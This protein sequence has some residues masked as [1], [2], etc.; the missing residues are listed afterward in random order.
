[1]SFVPMVGTVAAVTLVGPPPPTLAA[2]V[3]FGFGGWLLAQ[4]VPRTVSGQPLSLIPLAVSAL[5]A[6]R[7]ARAGRN[8][9]RA[10]GARR[11]S[12][13]R[14]SL[15]VAVTIA[16][17]YGGI[18]ALLAL[19]A[20]GADLRVGVL[21]AGLTL[22]IF[23]GV[24]ALLGAF[25]VSGAARSSR[26]R[27]PVIVRDAMRTAVIGV[28]FLIAVGAVAAGA[29]IATAGSTATA[30]LANMRLGI[31]AEAGIVLVCLAFAPNLA[32]WSAAFLA[33]PGFTL[34]RV[35]ELP[36]FAG[37][38]SRPVSGLGQVLLITPVLAGCAAGVLLAR[39]RRRLA[40]GA[41][42]ARMLARRPPPPATPKWS[43]LYAGLLTIPFAVGLIGCLGYLAAGAL[44]SG[45]LASTG[46]VG[47]EF[48]AIGA[49]GIGLGAT[50]TSAIA[51]LLSDA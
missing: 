29:A 32:V 40:T 6:W 1:V 42:A 48:A 24:S 10:I 36:V 50:V 47:W 14:P 31:A 23:A 26:V 20:N 7:C 49:T 43:A 22:G 17:V 38:P 27:V 34:A 44:G 3:R 11:S 13:P 41:K 37:L 8:T 15:A 46:Q 5:A 30:I 4:V 19:V 16:C 39:R 2:C 45:P 12:S 21:R 28:L 33:G 35:P 18:G 25:R 51:V 9:M